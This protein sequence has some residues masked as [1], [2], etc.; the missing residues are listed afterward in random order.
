MKSLHCDAVNFLPDDGNYFLSK[1]TRD[2]VYIDFR[3][4]RSQGLVELNLT[5]GL[6]S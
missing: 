1:T 3:K 2:V 6:H 4:L 5:D